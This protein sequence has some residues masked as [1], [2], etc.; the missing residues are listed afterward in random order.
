MK[1]KFISL[2]EEIRAP[3]LTASIIPVLLGTAIAWT[4]T[5]GFH[6]GHFILTLLGGVCL[7][8]GT[9]IANDYFDHV[10]GND[11]ANTE[12]VR[13]FSGGSRLI[14]TGRLAPREVLIESLVF[15]ALSSLI[16]LYLAWAI[17]WPII[18]L[19]LIG[20][21]SGF[22]YCAPPFKFVYRGLGEL[23]VGLNFGVL[24]TLGAY[25]TQTGSFS[26]EAAVASLP[27]GI[28]IAAVLYIN[29]FPDYNADK[30][31]GKNTLVVR[32]GKE[33]GVSFYLFLMALVYIVIAGSV[34][35][36]LVSPF[37]LLGFFTLPLA[38]PAMKTARQNFA[39]PQALAPANAGTIMVHLL[40]GVL[41]IIGYLL[42]KLVLG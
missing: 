14:Q 37:A 12:Y 8:A 25:F 26:L 13:P 15:F 11:E 28:L 30:K 4:R 32:L 18:T 1:E 33:I 35:F 23:L 19:G 42:H 22:F 10:S 20:L 17:G 36:R 7:H 34:I 21:V 6:S 16:G 2:L 24:M 29:E 5:G 38:I 3:F 41:L 39:D 9:N 40:T 31:V 27:I